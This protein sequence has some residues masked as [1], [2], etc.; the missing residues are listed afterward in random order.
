MLCKHY[1]LFIFI[2]FSGNVVGYTVVQPCRHC[3]ESCNNG[4]FWMFNSNA[5]EGRD[6]PDFTGMSKTGDICKRTLSINKTYFKNVF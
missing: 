4:H 2:N 5:V 3:L 1:M 6:R